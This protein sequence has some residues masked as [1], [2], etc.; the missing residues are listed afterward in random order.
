MGQDNLFLASFSCVGPTLACAGTAVGIVSTVPDGH[1]F[2]NAYIGSGQTKTASDNT[3]QST[4]VVLHQPWFFGKTRLVL[5]GGLTTGFLV[6]QQFQHSSSIT[7]TG[8]SATSST[9]I[10]LSND[11]R[12]RLAPM[13]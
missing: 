2:V 3:Q 12:Y 11:T 9:V 7:G 4:T 5:S 6:K 1:G 8:A 13:L 10:G